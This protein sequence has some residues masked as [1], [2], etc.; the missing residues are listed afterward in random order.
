MVISIIRHTHKVIVG[1]AII[2]NNV[3]EILK[4]RINA[5][6]KQTLFIT[7]NYNKF[8]GV[9]AVR[10][11]NE[12]LMLNKLIHQCKE[13]KPFLFGCDAVSLATKWYNRCKSEVPEE[14]HDKFILLTAEINKPIKDTEQEFK[15]KYVFY[16]PKITYGVDFSIDTPQNVYTYQK[17]DTIMPN[18]TNHA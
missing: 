4:N 17:G 10:V 16:S 5:E 12:Q 18:G 13:G 3:F 6:G 11:R 2:L 14:E 8:Q 1:D 9:P 7:N 15:N